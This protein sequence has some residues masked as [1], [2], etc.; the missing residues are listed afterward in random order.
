MASQ[1]CDKAPVADLVGPDRLDVLLEAQPVD[2]VAQNELSTGQELICNDGPLGC[3]PFYSICIIVSELSVH[4]LGAIVLLW[5]F[6][7]LWL[8]LWRLFLVLLLWLLN[9]V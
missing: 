1:V 5:L 9:N 7:L 6:W 4:L 8:W 3:A 2:L